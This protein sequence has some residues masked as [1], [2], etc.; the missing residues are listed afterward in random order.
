MKDISERVSYLQGLSEGLNISDGTPQGKIISG[1][2]GVLDT[3]AVSMK[4]FD[5]E[6]A[7]IREY[8]QSVDEDLMDLENNL[9]EED[10]EFVEIQCDNCGEELC[11]KSQLLESDERIEIICPQCNEVVFVN[12]GSFDFE[13]DLDD[14]EL[15][16]N[17]SN[18][19]ATTSS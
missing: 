12:D 15:G 7:S 1:I 14:D 13:P 17:K 16:D 10:D 18:H 8:I 3:M 19:Q 4:N 5:E 2:L 9:A 11:F 6:L